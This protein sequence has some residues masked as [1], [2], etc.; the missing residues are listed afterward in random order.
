MTYIASMHLSLPKL[1]NTKH[2]LL[3]LPSIWPFRYRRQASANRAKQDRA[4]VVGAGWLHRATKLA[5]LATLFCLQTSHAVTGCGFNVT[6]I[7]G[8]ASADLTNDGLIVTRHIRGITGSA[9][10]TGTRADQSPANLAATLAGINQHMANYRAAHDIDAS[11]TV[12]SND[13][14]LIDRHLAGFRGAALSDG[15][16]LTGGRSGYADIQTYI[17]DGCPV[18]LASNPVLINGGFEQHN[19]FDSSFVGVIGQ[20]LGWF[21]AGTEASNSGPGWTFNG[22]AG[23]QRNTSAFS[24]DGQTD[25]EGAQTAWVQGD[26]QI[27]TLV[28]MGAGQYALTFQHAQRSNF[29][30]QQRVR[31]WLDDVPV[32]QDYTPEQSFSAATVNLNISSAGQHKIT[33]AATVAGD[34]TAFIDNVALS[35]IGG[36]QSAN[37]GNVVYFHNDPA[38]TPLI[39]TDVN[40]AALW[41]EN[42]RPY[43]ERINQAAPTTPNRNT[44]GTTLGYTGKP[45]DADTGLSYLGARYYDP[46]IGRLTGIDPAPVDETNPHSFNRYAYA[47]NNPYRFVDPDGRVAFLVALVPFIPEITAGA[48]AMLVA[49]R[50]APFVQ[51]IL[52]AAMNTVTTLTNSSA[53]VNSVEVAS[54]F[55]PGAAPGSLAP[56]GVVVKTASGRRLGDFTKADKAAAKAENAVQHG[57]QMQCADCG[58][59]LENVASRKGVATPKNQA[60]VHHDPPIKDGG[61]RHSEAVVLCPTCHIERH[62]QESR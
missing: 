11:G 58:R 53:M 32:G 10:I 7:G 15:L 52:P 6:G 29:G 20:P 17:A 19:I 40:G 12:D 26:G 23:V 5:A 46:V 44:A 57:G 51:R 22:S 47:N 4:T 60:Q 42:Y 61:G 36:Q 2:S 37:P 54:G 41:K 50:A 3:S 38:G 1:H 34:N 24:G 25:H 14:I 59:A 31:V 62:I 39:A 16:T 35:R 56:A 28:D 27:S 30:G 21:K 33:F 43:G 18:V 49:A 8:E 55:V 48:G 13:A 45:F 9:L